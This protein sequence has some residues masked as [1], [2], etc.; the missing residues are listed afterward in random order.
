MA[1]PLLAFQRLE[2]VLLQ[3]RDGGMKRRIRIWGLAAVLYGLFVFWYT[4]TGGALQPHEIER[5][6]ERLTTNGE[7]AEKIASLRRFMETDSGRQFLMINLVDMNEGPSVASGTE[8]AHVKSRVNYQASS[9]TRHTT[10]G[11]CTTQLRNEGRSLW[12]LQR[13]T[14]PLAEET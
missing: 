13:G 7:S 1:D 5:F 9:R 4:N 11:R 14:P 8:L 12:F 2:G 6:L 3:D 10:L